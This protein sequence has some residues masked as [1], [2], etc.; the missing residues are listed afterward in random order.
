MCTYV[1]TYTY[2]YTPAHRFIYTLAKSL[3]SERWGR[4]VSQTKGRRMK[5]G[6]MREGERSPQSLLDSAGVHAEEGARRHTLHSC[7]LKFSHTHTPVYTSSQASAISNIKQSKHTAAKVWQR[8]RHTYT[9]PAHTQTN[10]T[11]RKCF[12]TAESAEPHTQSQR[13]MCLCVR[14]CKALFRKTW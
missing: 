13:G 11:L 7:K 1:S 4:T 14:V 9:R 6:T 3:A 8:E 12:R 5:R 2:I 10:Q